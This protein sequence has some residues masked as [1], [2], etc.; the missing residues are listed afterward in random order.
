MSSLLTV[1]NLMLYF[2]VGDI[3]SATVS[4]QL[5]KM[6]IAKMKKMQVIN[7]LF[8]PFNYSFP[9]LN[10]AKTRLLKKTTFFGTIN[11][12]AVEHYHDIINEFIIRL[13][14]E[15]ELPHSQS[16]RDSV[17]SYANTRPA[18]LQLLFVELPTFDGKPEMFE[19]FIASFEQSIANFKLSEFE[20]FYY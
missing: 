10:I 6:K 4:S 20:K 2:R 14:S 15:L 11:R 7:L 5:T 12:E 17:S 13:E 18:K 3:K 16:G 8:L 9:S 1:V 19:Q